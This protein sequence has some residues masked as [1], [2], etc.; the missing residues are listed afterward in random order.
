MGA[1]CDKNNPHQRNPAYKDPNAQ[2][3]EGSVLYEE[4]DYENFIGVKK[5]EHKQIHA[6]L[7][8]DATTQGKVWFIE[9]PAHVGHR[10]DGI[11]E[12]VGESIGFVY[13]VQENTKLR[14][15]LIKNRAELGITI[16]KLKSPADHD[17]YVR[18]KIFDANNHITFVLET[19]TSSHKTPDKMFCTREVYNRIVAWKTEN[20]ILPTGGAHVCNYKR[21]EISIR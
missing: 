11:C 18:K 2:I 16:R 21:L 9:I 10:P 12:P 14:Q 15:M 8:E 5:T 6:T 13:N 20:R 3:E 17:F 1:L 4:E 19:K 7:S